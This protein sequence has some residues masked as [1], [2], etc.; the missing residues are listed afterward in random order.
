MKV[1]RLF[2]IVHILLNKERVTARELAEQFEVSTR[3]IYRDIDILSRNN[4]PIYT[5]KGKG[6]GISLLD[7]FVLDKSLISE[8]E[9]NSIMVGLEILK[10][11]KYDEVNSAVEKLRSLF[12]TSNDSYIEVDFSMWESDHEHKKMFSDIK[13]SLENNYVCELGYMDSLGEVSLR[14][15][16]PLK[17]IFKVQR[18]Y[19]IAFCQLKQDY[20]M[21]R[22]TRFKSL[23]V[24]EEVF[25]RSE[26]DISGIVISGYDKSYDIKVTLRLDKAAMFRV[27]EEFEP[28]MI[29]ECGEQII[30]KFDMV[31]DAYLHNYIMSFGEY[32]IDVEPVELKTIVRHRAK[33]ILERL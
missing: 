13:K 28:D 3:T 25:N 23:R 15:I 17:L 32:L 1:D 30:V 21:F 14:K 16:N 11:T 6:G 19:L 18:W 9:R 4:V 27:R 5:D 31:S 12:D 8:E 20:R 10:V 2:S 24:C 22:L 26:F 29:S 33:K 7:N